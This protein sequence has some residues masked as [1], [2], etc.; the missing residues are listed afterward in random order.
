MKL[1]DS[2]SLKSNIKIYDKA[3]SIKNTVK[4]ESIS[5]RN[6]SFIVKGDNTY[7]SVIY[8]E[9]KGWSCDCKYYS[10]HGRICSHIIAV[11]LR[12]RE[13]LL[14]YKNKE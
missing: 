10:I 9:N 11:N 5:L 3:L 13:S 6:I 12:L 7:H 4:V 14:C 1:L 8:I 2:E